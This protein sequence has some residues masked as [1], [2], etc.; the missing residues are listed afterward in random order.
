VTVLDVSGE[1]DILNAADLRAKMQEAAADAGPLIVSLKN[2][3]YFDS[4]T[5]EV[6]VV[7]SKRLELSRRT[8]MLVA[9]RESSARRLL[10]VSGIST[11]IA[12]FADLEAA[13]G[14]LLPKND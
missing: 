2:V 7:F 10:D 4:Q 8:L 11:A 6:L 1:I 13:L 9:P 12:T 14:S 5:L 3:S